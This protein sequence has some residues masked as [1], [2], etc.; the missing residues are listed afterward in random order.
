VSERDIVIAEKEVGKISIRS[1]GGRR[2][3]E[4]LHYFIDSGVMVG[5]NRAVRTVQ[6]FIGV[7]LKDP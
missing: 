5:S 6:A 3:G 1:L 2:G 7:W 4:G